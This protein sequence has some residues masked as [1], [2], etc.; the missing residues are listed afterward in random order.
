MK[1]T[2][3]LYFLEK[4]KAI[5]SDEIKKLAKTIKKLKESFR[6]SEISNKTY[7][8]R[9][10]IERSIEVSEKASNDSY[11][12]KRYNDRNSSDEQKTKRLDKLGGH[13]T[14][15]DNNL[16]NKIIDKPSRTAFGIA[17]YRGSKDSSF[18][19]DSNN[20]NDTFERETNQENV[21]FKGLNSSRN[22]YES[23]ATAGIV[24]RDKICLKK[25]NLEGLNAKNPH[26][27]SFTSENNENK[28]ESELWKDNWSKDKLQIDRPL[29][30]IINIDKINLQKQLECDSENWKSNRNSN[31]FIN[32]V[33]TK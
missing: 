19:N 25:L 9:N 31:S 7:E 14:H 21:N 28:N 23:L 17:T 5:E 33:K 13:N 3:Q 6:N 1:V 24:D 18:A 15:F 22:K 32:K 29:S 30:S 10:E 12:A 8:R 26:G 2:D 4:S 27:Y 11:W 16:I 20:F